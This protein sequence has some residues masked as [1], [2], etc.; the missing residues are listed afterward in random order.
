[1][2]YKIIK[3]VRDCYCLDKLP[4]AEAEDLGVGSVVECSCG[5]R[6][7]RRGNRYGDIYWRPLPRLNVSEEA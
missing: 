3:A 5:R 4:D 7:E 2:S 1:V 6:Y